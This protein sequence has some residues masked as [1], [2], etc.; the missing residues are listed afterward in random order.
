MTDSQNVIRFDAAAVTWD[1]NPVRVQMAAAV[2]DG[3]AGHIDL[4]ADMKALDIGC[5]TGL[6]ALPLA[7]RVGALTAADSSPVMLK[8]LAAKAVAAG[9]T[10]VVTVQTDADDDFNVTGS[11]NLVTCVMVL[12]HIN[13]IAAM[14]DKTSR[15]MVAGGTLV[16]VDLYS[17][18]GTFHSDPR[19]VVHNGLDPLWLSRLMIAAGLIPSDPVTVH[20]VRRTDEYSKATREYPLFMLIG[21][22]T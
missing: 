9:L 21:R 4:T 2:Y 16:L 20:T 10:N 14:I 11:F 12:H 18:D 3:I 7:A 5:G 19:S 6:I 8:V 15:M 22:K 1:D 13:D 17:E